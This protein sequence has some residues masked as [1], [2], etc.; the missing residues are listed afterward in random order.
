VTVGPSFLAFLITLTY[1][2]QALAFPLK[3]DDGQ[4]IAACEFN[5]HPAPEGC[6]LDTGT[7]Y[8]AVPPSL[9]ALSGDFP[10][11]KERV[12]PGCDLRN[13][14]IKIGEINFVTKS[15][16]RC[17][18]KG[19]GAIGFSV[20][21]SSTWKFDMVANEVVR[22][23]K[24]PQGL[25]SGVLSRHPQGHFAIPIGIG[26]VSVTAVF[27]T[28]SQGTIFMDLSLLNEL[29]AQL[30]FITD[31]GVM[32]EEDKVIPTKRYR[33][34]KLIIAGVVFEGR[35]VI[36]YDFSQTIDRNLLAVGMKAAIGQGIIRDHVWIFDLQNNKWA[37]EK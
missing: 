21:G 17:E 31:K 2:S 10:K 4:W 13:A 37:I 22:L 28:G 18:G 9:Y 7:P 35:D 29:E 1:F 34:S 11:T 14:E 6:L 30:T 25:K 33:A 15:I 3:F 27:D 16:L 8:D 19:M 5:G 32:V 26:T 12:F 24:I 23:N 20:L 36:F